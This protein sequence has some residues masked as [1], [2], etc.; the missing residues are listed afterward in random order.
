MYK[1]LGV[2]SKFTVRQ[3]V[4]ILKEID[5]GASVVDTY[6]KLKCKSKKV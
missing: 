3:I 1:S 2:K 5:D 4:T 6:Y